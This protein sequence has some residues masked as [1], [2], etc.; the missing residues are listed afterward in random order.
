MHALQRTAIL[1]LL[2]MVESAVREIRAVLANGTAPVSEPGYVQPAAEPQ[3]HQSMHD[4]SLTE[5]EDDTLEEMMEKHRLDLLNASQNMAD[6][7][8]RDA[9]QSPV[10]DG[11]FDEDA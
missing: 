8:Y 5:E 3:R 2:G 6:K 9:G 7:F 11:I 4:M 1:A 10:L